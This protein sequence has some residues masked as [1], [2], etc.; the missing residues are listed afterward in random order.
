VPYCRLFAAALLAV[1]AVP[2]FADDYYVN[3]DTGDDDWDG[4]SPVPGETHGP[5]A[6]IQAG[7]NAASSGDAVHVADGTYTGGLNK[8]LD[9]GGKA[10]TLRSEGGARACIIDCESDGRGFHFHSGESAGSVLQ[11][12]TVTGGNADDG[13]GILCVGSSPT[14]L[15]CTIEANAAAE[16]GGGVCCIGS[17]PVISNCTIS[18]NTACYGGGIECEDGADA[19][20]TDCTVTANV[21]WC[22]GGG[23]YC[24]RSRP[25]LA[26]ST[27]SLNVAN[28]SGGGGINCYIDSNATITDCAFTMNSAGTYGG[29]IRCWGSKPTIT[30]CLVV[31][32]TAADSGGGLSCQ[33]ESAPFFSNCTVSGNTAARYAGGLYCVE[34]SSSTLWNCILWDDTPGELY[35]GSGTPAVIYC[36]VQ[37]GWTGLG[38]IDAD[39]LF[40]RGP[41]HAYYLSQIAA[42]QATDS[43]CVDAGWP[44]GLLPPFD[45]ITTRTDGV[46]DSGVIDMGYHAPYALWIDSIV[47]AGADVTI[48]WNARSGVSY[49]V[50]W[51]PYPDSMAWNEVGVGEATEWTDSDTASCAQRFYRIREGDAPLLSALDGAD[52]VER[53]TGSCR[54]LW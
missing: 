11:G 20:I 51:S 30:N 28:A 17:S 44:K 19:Q 40:V 22:L 3:A 33:G 36:D 34:G 54:G 23:V 24:V 35:V 38:N 13:G 46:P 50:E 12:F 43:P 1:L 52:S 32:N 15:D 53:S 25:T 2:A 9:F 48:H 4:L 18:A 31:G 8:N 10:L 16:E 49:V 29:G 41:L 39:P 14:I 45:G 7:L 37:A 6:T 47:R 26:R 5:K 42:G 21:A 27:I